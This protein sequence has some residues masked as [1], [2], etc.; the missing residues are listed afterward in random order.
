MPGVETPAPLLFCDGALAASSIESAS[1]PTAGEASDD[2]E[3]SAT[4]FADMSAASRLGEAEG[5]PKRAAAVTRAISVA[6]AAMTNLRRRLLTSL[7]FDSAVSSFS[8][9]LMEGAIPPFRPY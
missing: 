8:S 7:K 3:A 4:T 1:L 2:G 5:Q 6:V 9:G